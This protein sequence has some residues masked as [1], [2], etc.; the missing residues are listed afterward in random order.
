MMKDE[1]K[2]ISKIDLSFKIDTAKK[3][4]FCLT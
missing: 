3:K 4:L 1:K 2:Q